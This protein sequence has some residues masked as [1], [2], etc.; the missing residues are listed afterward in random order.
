MLKLLLKRIKKDDIQQFLRFCV[1][2]TLNALIDFAVLDLLLWRFPT[3]STLKALEYNSLAV[4]LASTNSFFWNKYWT[5]KQRSPITSRE[6]GRF[7]V[8]ALGTTLMNDLLIWFLS[9]IFPSFMQSSLIAANVLKLGAIVGTLSISFFGMRLWVFFQKK[10]TLEDRS[11]NEQVADE[12]PVTQLTYEVDMI[13]EGAIKP[14]Y[15]MDMA[16]TPSSRLD[17]KA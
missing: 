16:G 8:I 1:V 9:T 14:S 2:G 11:Q 5:F 13:I 17:S 12:A 3:S 4:I 10:Y 7:L 15:E 6:V